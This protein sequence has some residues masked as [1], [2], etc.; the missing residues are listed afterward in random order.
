MT[1]SLL[2]VFICLMGGLTAVADEMTLTWSNGDILLGTLERVDG[3]VL[4][5]KSA[6][7][8]EPLKIRLSSLASVTFSKLKTTSA[9]NTDF[10]I[11]MKNGDLLNGNLD[12]IDDQKIS[13]TSPR[14][15]RFSVARRQILGLQKSRKNSGVI[16]SGPHGLEGWQP[17]FRRSPDQQANPG[18]AVV[19][20]VDQALAA[21]DPAK[22]KKADSGVA[23]TEQPDGSLTT[24]RPDAALFL[25][26]SLPGKFEIELELHSKKTLSFVM[27]VGHDAKAGLRLESWID[28]LVA[29][30]G[31]QFA[32]LQQIKNKDQSL[33]LHLYVDYA[34]RKMLVY[35][36][37]GDKLGEIATTGLRGAAQGI[38]LR[39][40]EW[41][42]SLRRLRITAWDGN[43]P[44]FDGQT[45]TRIQMVD[46][47]S[48][49]GTI[50][51]L[52]R[53]ESLTLTK[54][55]KTIDLPLDKIAAVLLPQESDSEN[56]VRGTTQIVWKDGGFISG[57]LISAANGRAL[58]RTSYSDSPVQ[59]ELTGALRI[60]LTPGK[61]PSSQT[62]Q[63]FHAQGS[64]QGN[65]VVD[66]AAESPVRWRPL[67]GLNDAA[68]TFSGNA[69][70]QRG[71][72]R[73]HF[74]S[75]PD[76]LAQ[77][78]DVIYLRNSD[79]LP[80]RIERCS[81]EAVQLSLP[82]SKVSSFQFKEIKAIELS[83]TG[84]I[85]QRGFSAKG[86]KGPK[87]KV[88]KPETSR[89][90]SADPD[91]QTVTADVADKSTALLKDTVTLKG[92]G[93]LS[94][95]QILTGDTVRFHLKWPL[96][97][98]ANL[99]VS[100]FG[101]GSRNDSD[102]T[103]VAF[104][105]MQAAMQVLDRPPNQ[106]QNQMFFRGF[107]G[108][109]PDSI[110]RAPQG[111][112]DVQLVAKDGKLVVSVN[113]KEVKSLPL[114]TAGAGKKGL[115]FNAN[116]TLMGNVVVNGRVQQGRTDGVE[117]SAFEIDNMSGASIRQFIDDEVRMAALTIPRFRRDNPPAHVLIA[118][119]GDLLR[120]RL[121]GVVDNDIQ[122]ESRLETLRIGRE[123]IAAIV[124]LDPPKKELAEKQKLLEDSAETSRSPNTRVEEIFT[125]VPSQNMAKPQ[126]PA[127]QSPVIS[128]VLSALGFEA[129][130]EVSPESPEIA[131]ETG[132]TN[133]ADQAQMPTTENPAAV[134]VTVTDTDG[135]ETSR[136]PSEVRI[137]LADGFQI[138]MIP[139]QLVNGQMIGTSPQ[140]GVCSF[141]AATIRELVFGNAEKEAAAGA[142]QHWISR[143][144]QEPDWDVAA[145]D[146]G[147]SAGSQLIGQVAEDFELSL[148]DGTRFR[149]SDHA[150]KIVVLDFWATWCGPCVAA[151]PDYVAAT[152]RFDAS[153]VIFVA[154][155][156]QESSD[157]IRS[158]LFERELSPAVAL[159]RD[160]S[161]GEKFRVSGIPHTVILGK[162]NVVEDVHVGYQQGGGDSMRIAIQ[163]LLD[164]TWKRA[165][166]DSDEA[167]NTTPKT[168]PA[169]Q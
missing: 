32:T 31:T 80:C 161:A 96:Q 166:T 146:G 78:P 101:D 138:S 39:N 92:N 102:A 110:I 48:H 151:L 106:A 8:T 85:H 131:E 86:W 149:L 49:L 158:F 87:P 135:A 143:N 157:Q 22:P 37:A 77:F 82:F 28:V 116:V 124:F 35:S 46:G 112:A 23:W 107:G 52:K 47:S 84:R 56:I 41:D 60:S 117:I 144:A 120:G 118:A 97:S 66:D 73:V 155:N 103:H 168:P 89:K 34:G 64:L 104:S 50:E 156:Q 68:L 160:G 152:S 19:Q 5:W 128:S 132:Q 42:L 7:F 123:R 139:T 18:N 71:A 62:D 127:D 93:S 20:I 9:A 126:I 3:E 115:A 99:T 154:V 10:Q 129:T 142:Y 57:N 75:I 16:Y 38:T 17:A 44:R 65:L 6:L 91:E 14:L 11:L 51:S 164:G 55:G 121:M 69:R 165:G 27:A 133:K 122:F 125:E 169:D 163:Q 76:L 58:I 4:T 137:Q 67:G 63:L 145:D 108:Q 24:T 30:N 111:E 162:G 134:T 95:A 100:L 159:D 130:G 147:Q 61:E 136:E 141:P 83:A 25:P 12:S 53:G 13:F 119:T 54:D 105:L 29:A 98:N 148:L 88:S 79:V 2:A 59:C 40:G 140:L 36:A 153:K 150:D 81:D 1:R 114:N 90:P 21:H 15:G 113:G 72:G 74:A 45:E 109:N 26:L 33:H 94:H 167:E 70:I 43:A